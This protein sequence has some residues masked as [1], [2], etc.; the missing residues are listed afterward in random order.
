MS[1]LCTGPFSVLLEKILE[2]IAITAITLAS[3]RLLVVVLK[4]LG[5][6]KRVL[7]INRL[8]FTSQQET[9]LRSQG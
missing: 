1:S 4:V 3:Q 5:E 6:K 9:A 2:Q 7:V 8:N